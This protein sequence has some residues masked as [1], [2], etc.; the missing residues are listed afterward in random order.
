MKHQSKLW[1]SIVNAALLTTLGHIALASEPKPALGQL[2]FEGASLVLPMNI[3]T[4][5]ARV[6]VDLGDGKDHLFVVDTGAAIN[7]IDA[8]IAESLGLNVVGE[9]EIGAPGGPKIPG[10]IVK[11]TDPRLG[12]ATIKGGEFVTMDLDTFSR[13]T[14]QGVLGLGLFKNYLLTYDYEKSEIRVTRESLSADEP[15]VMPYSDQDGHIQI[16]IDVA[17]TPLAT[18]ID[19][20]SMAGFTLPVELQ[21]SLTLAPDGQ[22]AGNA[23]LVG[24]NRN[25]TLGQLEG[26]IIFA[27]ETYENPNVGFMDPSPGYGNVGARVLRDFV[28]SI[29]QENHL[30]RFAK[31]KRKKESTADGTP[32]RL[33]VQFRGMPGGS[34]L[35]I[36]DVQPGSLGE[37][38][39][40]LPGDVLTKL[41]GMPAEE[42]DMPTLGA[43]IRG[44]EPLVLE[45][46]RDGETK[47]IEI[48]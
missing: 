3:Q 6:T 43:L 8:A 24:G 10:N 4:G 19:T 11:A 46:E 48:Q 47:T 39:G 17:G 38:S 29:D 32:R 45:V 22:R 2:Q 33:G 40:L 27:G 7:V 31:T 5:H 16:D 9:M 34:T 21:D 1:R 28:V 15:G 41:N 25:I 20:G 26:S 35:E 13:G 18:H 42:Y 12:A 30:I 37:Q 23:R 36:G 14:M 44:D